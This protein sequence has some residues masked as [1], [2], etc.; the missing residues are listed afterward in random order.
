M[1]TAEP[2]TALELAH[3]LLSEFEVYDIPEGG[4]REPE[5]TLHY[6]MSSSI[7]VRI[8]GECTNYHELRDR[9]AEAA[10]ACRQQ[11][12]HPWCPEPD[13]GP[14]PREQEAY[15]LLRLRAN[16]MTTAAYEAWYRDELGTSSQFPFL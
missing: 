15:A 8:L 12:P 16:E 9:L 2:C 4:F 5:F 13:A 10:A 14:C 1:P 6:L 3:A 7:L 11:R